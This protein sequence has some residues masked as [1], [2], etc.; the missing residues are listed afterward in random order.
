MMTG[1]RVINRLKSGSANTYSCYYYYTSMKQIFLLSDKKLP[2]IHDASLRYRQQRV[3]C[4]RGESVE[5]NEE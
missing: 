1:R 4:K 5:R 2:A 3:R